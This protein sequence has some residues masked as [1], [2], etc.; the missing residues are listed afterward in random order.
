[1]LSNKHILITG[2]SGTLGA[3]LVNA[4]LAKN[5][6]V[7]F[8][9]AAHREKAAALTAAGAHAFPCD[10]SHPEET[11]S[12][13]TKIKNAVPRLDAVI[14]NAAAVRDHVITNMSPAEWNH[15]LSVDFLSIQRMAY[16]LRPLLEHARTAA[17]P[18]KIITVISRVGLRGAFGQANYAAAKDAL[19]EFTR[20]LAV[21]YGPY[22]I[23]VNAVNPGFMLSGM[24]DFLSAA[25]RQSHKEQSILR[26]Y[27]DPHEVAEFM[28]FLCSDACTQVSGQVFHYESRLTE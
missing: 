14:F 16:S 10:F 24:T 3:A 27:S 15:V 6:Q 18:S 21:D 25:V 20:Y 17:I 5:A 7:Y 11:S 2:G 22:N 28:L 8:T 19:I 12:F 13:I 4:A 1:M 9:V 23:A 26:R